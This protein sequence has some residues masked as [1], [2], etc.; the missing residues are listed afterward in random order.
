MQWIIVYAVGNCPLPRLERCLGAS[1]VS[2][3]FPAWL[4][5]KAGNL[6]LIRIA[7]VLCVVDVGHAL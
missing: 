2:V 5:S 6:R 1:H 7:P 3:D 4:R